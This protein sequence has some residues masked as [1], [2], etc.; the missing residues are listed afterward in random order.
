M[1]DLKDYA[2]KNSKYASFDE[3][4]IIEGVF[5]GAK[6]VMK[7]SFSEEKEVVRYKIDGKTFDSM[8]GSLATQMDD[9]KAGSK[10]KIRRSG[11][12]AET[13]YKVEIL[14]AQSKPEEGWPEETQR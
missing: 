14:G 8:S 5:E 6:I 4:G 2:K 10:V 1:G 3:D 12:G 13:K 7:D 9:V 11:Q